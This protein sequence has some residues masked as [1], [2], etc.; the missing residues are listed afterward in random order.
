MNNNFFS[1]K[2]LK[3][4]G[5]KIHGNNIKVSKL[6]R[7]YNPKKLILNDNI[8]IDDF[9][10]LSGKGKI[11]IGN[12]VHIGPHCF[13]SSFTNIKFHDFS[14]LSSGVKLFGSSDD[15]SGNFMTNPT[16]P[17][18]YLGTIFGDII[19]KKHVII[20]ANSIILPNIT[21]KEGTAVGTSSL[22]NKNTEEWKIYAGNPAKIIKNREKKCIEHE[23][24]LINELK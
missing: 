3:K 5:I 16:V 10:I 21:L 14:G 4:M 24:N 1:L 20:G 6:A 23:L 15:Y 2:N 17:S 12:Y 8:R 11:E 7:I 22:I 9:T 18:K 13:I 19:L